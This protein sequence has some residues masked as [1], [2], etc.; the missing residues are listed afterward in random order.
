METLTSFDSFNGPKKEKKTADYYQKA[1]IINSSM[2]QDLLTLSIVPIFSLTGHSD[3][4]DRVIGRT[5][6][7][8][9]HLEGL[10]LAPDD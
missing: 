2:K 10:F 9:S 4:M 5:P 7:F 6:E 3:K 1:F 8:Q